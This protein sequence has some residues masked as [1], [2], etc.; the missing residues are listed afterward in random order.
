MLRAVRCCLVAGVPVLANC[1]PGPDQPPPPATI[2]DAVAWID[3]LVLE[4]GD[5]TLVGNP[6]LRADP[7]GGWL[8]WDTQLNQARRY[9]ASG[10]LATTF[11]RPGRGPGELSSVR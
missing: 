8:Y 9:D 4:E 11:G 6:N 2:D 3:T 1:A 7:A 10:T 5:S